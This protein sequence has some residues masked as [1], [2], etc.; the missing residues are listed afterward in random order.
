MY[1]GFPATGVTGYLHPELRNLTIIDTAISD[2]HS[3]V[4]AKLPVDNNA[5]GW[6]Y[7]KGVSSLGALG[8]GSLRTS[9][10][11]FEIV[12]FFRDNNIR[13]RDCEVGL[14]HTACLSTTARMFVFGSGSDGNVL[15]PGLQNAFEPVEVPLFN[16][17]RIGAGQVTTYALL[18]RLSALTSP[19]RER[20]PLCLG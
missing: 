14:A 15:L 3:V 8:L 17:T 11:T 13:V 9:T 7:S 2:F 19:R 4:I 18:G 1:G 20:L 12:P 10:A 6:V 5:G 16:V